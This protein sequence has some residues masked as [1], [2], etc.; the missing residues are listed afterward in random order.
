[1][2]NCRQSTI[3]ARGLRLSRHRPG[4]QTWQGSSGLR[5]HYLLQEENTHREAQT[6]QACPHPPHPP[7]FIYRVERDF[8]FDLVSSH[9]I[10]TSFE[11]TCGNQKHVIAQR[12]TW[13]CM[14]HTA[15]GSH[16][17]LLPSNKERPLFSLQWG[18]VLTDSHLTFWGTPSYTVYEGQSV[19]IY[20][21]IN[22]NPFTPSLLF[23]LID[24]PAC[25]MPPFPVSLSY[26]QG[27]NIIHCVQRNVWWPQISF[28]KW[29]TEMSALLGFSH[30]LWN[31]DLV[32]Q[33]RISHSIQR[34]IW[35]SFIHARVKIIA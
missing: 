7:F 12:R 1:M 27:E 24:I 3:W 31:S 22:L 32:N 25:N 26:W 28:K 20:A 14:V 35:R 5:S 4:P 15:S 9:D 34:C 19:C 30:L 10:F 33:I 18:E 6:A 16:S 11:K 23:S 13:I 17:S 21:Y 8:C 2:P 29:K